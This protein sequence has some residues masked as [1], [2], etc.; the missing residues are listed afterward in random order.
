MTISKAV[1]I[2]I[3]EVNMKGQALW[4]NYLTFMSWIYACSDEVNV[5]SVAEL[6]ILNGA[7]DPTEMEKSYV[8]IKCTPALF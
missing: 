3:Q 4:L 8:M 5:L 1:D 2:T 6:H 7:Q